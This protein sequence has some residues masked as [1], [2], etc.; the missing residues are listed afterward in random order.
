VSRGSVAPVGP[1]LAPRLRTSKESSEKFI[2]PIV[3][4]RHS[5]RDYAVRR[6]LA[7]ADLLALA[8]ALTVSLALSGHDRPWAQVPWGLLSL[9]VWV[10]VF[11]CYGLYDR[12]VKRVSHTAVD[13]L[14]GLLHSLLVGSLLLWLYFHA[15]P[16]GGW[17]FKNILI[18]AVVALALVVGLRATF[19]ALARSIVGAERVLLVGDT[20]TVG[21]LMRKMRDHPEYGLDPIG[22]VLQTPEAGGESEV[23]VLGSVGDL[24]LESLLEA[25]RVDRL[26]V[27]HEHLDG[28]A[29][30]DLV[31]RC[32]SLSIKVSVVPK[33]FDAMGT[34][35]EV[36]DVAGITVLGINP[37][38]LARSSR[39]LKRAMDVTGA[40]AIALICAPLLLAAAVAIRLGS[41]GPILFTQ[42]RVGKGGRRFRLLKFRTMV[43]DAEQ[44]RSDLLADSDDPHWLKL[45]HDPRVTRVGRI[46]RQT[47]LDELPQLWNIL[48]GQMSL[49]GPRPLVEGEA[50]QL[51]GWARHRIDLTPGL[52]GLWQVLGRTNIPFDEMV[53]LD[54]LYVTNWSLWTDVR[55]ILRTLPAVLMQRGAN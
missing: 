2:R 36:D 39:L 27:S 4:K 35:V 34:S 55:L 38:V 42:D 46:L 24:D 9:P 1:L 32:K 40:M 21:S 26:V 12:D 6:G 11:T 45:E 51:S 25:E 16:G 14:P 13:D 7:V 47:S 48:R 22:L 8:A 50:N 54:Y 41:R 37:P 18:F 53:K 10:A 3:A 23:P 30:L 5:P 19:R 33:L 17:D 20:D 44:K 49:V 29:M 52:T 15:V 31:R 43:P 28:N